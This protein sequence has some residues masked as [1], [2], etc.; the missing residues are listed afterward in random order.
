MLIEDKRLK[1][2]ATQS[3][4]AHLGHD[5]FSSLIKL[6]EDVRRFQLKTVTCIKY[7]NF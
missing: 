3:S 1:K 5:F 7:I 4:S 2:R 6:R